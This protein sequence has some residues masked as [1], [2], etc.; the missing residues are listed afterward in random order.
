[1]RLLES[2]PKVERRGGGAMTSMVVHA[3][4]IVAAAIGTAHAEVRTPGVIY[5]DIIP[6]DPPRDVPKPAGSAPVTPSRP[7]GGPTTPGRVITAPITI[8]I[9]IP[10]IDNGSEVVVSPPTRGDFTGGYGSGAEG[11]ISRD[12]SYG[13]P[14][15]S[16][17]WSAHTVEV[18]VVPDAHNPSPSY[19]EVLRSAGITG[20]VLAEFVVDSTGRVRANSLVIVETT[21][22]LFTLSIRRTVPSLRFTPARAQGRRVAQRVRV[23]FEFEIR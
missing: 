19:P 18:A 21:H 9:D 5:E 22:P 16:G 15:S 13:V 6:F 3:A 20:R 11:G 8:R 1:M 4:I 14:D 12:P 2:E 23:P 10:P 17:V 7:N